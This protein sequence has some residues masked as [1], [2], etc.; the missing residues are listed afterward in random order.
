[1]HML[2]NTTMANNTRHNYI[3]VLSLKAAKGANMVAI[4]VSTLS[5][6]GRPAAADAFFADGYG[7]G[8]GLTY[9]RIKYLVNNSV[10][11]R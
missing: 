1:M 11:G 7:P 6:R 9:N 2:S 8:G 10:A 3:N 4:A 5:S